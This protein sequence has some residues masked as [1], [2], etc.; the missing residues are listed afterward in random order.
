MRQEI[1][2]LKAEFLRGATSAEIFPPATLPEIAFAGRSNVGKSSLINSIIMRKN[3]ARTSS[4]PGKTREINFFD[5]EG[6]WQFAD[7]PGFGFAKAALSERE[8]WAKLNHGYLKDRE[9]LRLV[10]V[11]VDSRHDPQ[12]AD[13][14]LIE[15]LEII[16]R[17][18]VIILTKSDKIS[19]KQIGE[20]KSQVEGV[21]SACPHCVEVLPYSSVTGEGRL[22]LLAVIKKAVGA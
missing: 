1:K 7:M 22:Q 13:L 6:K 14:A 16:G 12:P 18:Y 15:E 17:R 4:E 2:P 10:C 9:N 21:V 5:V 19:A 8:K 3:V 20:R 11:L